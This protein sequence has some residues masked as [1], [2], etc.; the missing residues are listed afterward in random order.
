M[1]FFKYLNTNFLDYMSLE[2][3]WNSTYLNILT[4][5]WPAGREHS[6]ADSITWLWCISIPY[7]SK[8]IIY[9]SSTWT[10]PANEIGYTVKATYMLSWQKWMPWSLNL[11]INSQDIY[12][13]PCHLQTRQTKNNSGKCFSW[14]FTIIKMN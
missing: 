9:I 2:S 14:W 1:I 11:T 7:Q 13:Q 5:P 6:V 10:K 3:F 12:R 4:Y 8:S